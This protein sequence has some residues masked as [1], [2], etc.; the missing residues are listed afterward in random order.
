MTTLE[1]RI[2]ALEAKRAL[3]AAAATTSTRPPLRWE[4]FEPRLRARIAERDA[5]EARRAALPLEEQL[6][7]LRADHAAVVAKRATRTA[8]EARMLIPSFDA[9]EERLFAY[10]EKQL[11]DAMQA[12]SPEVA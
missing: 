2:A 11:L 4:E 3:A 9:I 6:R 8:E 1:K 7:L 5:E 12:A 10:R